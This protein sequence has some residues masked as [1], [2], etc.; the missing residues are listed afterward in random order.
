[1]SGSS[2]TRCLVTS[3]GT[4]L[5]NYLV[6]KPAHHLSTQ[7]GL[8]AARTLHSANLLLAH[9]DHGTVESCYYGLHNKVLT[10]WFPAEE[11]YEVSPQWNIPNMMQSI[12]F[13]VC[14]IMED[15]KRPI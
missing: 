2:A 13:V 4:L 11:G 6:Q 9:D 3:D 8:R 15:Q 7:V 1:M 14:H 5:Q 12:D 10:Y